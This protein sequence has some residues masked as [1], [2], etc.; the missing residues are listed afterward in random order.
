VDLIVTDLGV[1]KVAAKGH[2][3]GLTLVDIAPGVTLGELHH[4]TE[5]PFAIADDVEVTA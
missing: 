3:D 2:D 4:K 5:A 1:F